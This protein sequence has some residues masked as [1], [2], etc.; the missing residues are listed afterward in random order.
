MTQPPTGPPHDP[1]PWGHYPQPNPEPRRGRG[2]EI[3]GGVVVGGIAAVLVPL[4]VVAIASGA[5]SGFG[6][7]ELVLALVV[8]PLIGIGLMVNKASRPWGL[9][10]LIGWAI[11]VIVIGGSCVAI[12]ASLGN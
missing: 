7:A 10:I 11:A 9:G 2:W 12:I 3:F 4:I 6:G 5:G 1:P 8:V